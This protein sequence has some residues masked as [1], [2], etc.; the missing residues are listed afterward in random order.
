[1]TAHPFIYGRAAK[2]LVSEYESLTPKSRVLH[3]RLSNS[4][5]GGETRAVTYF[6]PYPLAIASAEGPYLV[7]QDGNTYIDLVNNMAS[8]VHG[9]R[10]PP[11]VQAVSEAYA[12]LGSVQAGSHKY[13]LELSELLVERY[14]AFARIRFTNSASEAAILALRIAR[15]V[16]GRSSFIMFEGAYHGMGSE[17]TDPDPSVIKVP[18]N[19]LPALSGVLDEKVAA[20]FAESFLGHAG[21]VP[22][23]P[24]FLRTIQDLCENVGALFVLDE[25]QSL[26]DHYSGHHGAVEVQPA[27]VIMGK[28]VG[29]GLPVGV[30]GGKK[31]LIELASAK[32]RGGLRHSGTFN[33]NVLTTA[34]GY[35]SML[36]LSEGAIDT[37]NARAAK[38]AKE[39]AAAG[40][41]LDLPIVVTRSGSTMCVHFNDRAP[42]NAA[43]AVPQTQLARWFHI[44]AL[45]EGVCVIRG[46][47]STCRRC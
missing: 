3:E 2:E 28:S 29:G 10:F 1:M 5:A 24:T 34:A 9:H 39:I 22:A 8:L 38:L 46:E 41:H 21:V 19:D 4:L 33:G 30:L 32:C 35:Q 20:V 44:A 7:D 26:R 37:L 31:E 13:L 40:D 45:L 17:F 25:T 11:I 18:F 42:R 36:A 6:E 12:L 15:R 23:E 27:M 47:G 16:T 43:E 14:P